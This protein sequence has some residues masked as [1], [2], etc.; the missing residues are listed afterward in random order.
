MMFRGH[1]REP[2]ICLSHETDV[3]LFGL[4]GKDGDDFENLGLDLACS[5]DNQ[6]ARQRSA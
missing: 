5:G 6:K 3:R 2:V 4:A 1:R